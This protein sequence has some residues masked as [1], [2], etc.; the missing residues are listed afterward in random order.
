MRSSASSPGWL[1][2]LIP[3]AGDRA[4]DPIDPAQ[5]LL[6]E[7]EIRTLFLR[8]LHRRRQQ[9]QPEVT[10]T[11]T[12][13]IRSVR[14]GPGLDYEESRA[15]QAGDE[16][17]FMNWRLSARTG[18][19]Q[20]KVF[21]E[22]R[23]PAVVLLIDRRDTMR[24]GTCKRLKLTQALR[25]A[26]VIGATA[27]Q[28]QASVSTLLLDE[29]LRWCGAETSEPG[30]LNLLVAA[31]AAAPPLPIG[32]QAQGFGQALDQLQEKLEPGSSLWL[33]S[34]FIDLTDEH[35]SRLLQLSAQAQVVAATIV[36]PA[37]RQLPTAGRLQFAT[38]QGPLSLDTSAP[39][40]QAAYARM[41]A[42]HYR[43]QQ[44]LLRD[45]G[46]A[47]RSLS[48]LDDDLDAWPDVQPDA[49]LATR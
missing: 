20:R 29:P 21:R 32:R 8:A 46:I 15:Y 41:A 23:R 5:P 1:Q 9:R 11:Q 27:Y 12:G 42:N 16:P 40:V 30:I 37:E 34:D 36:D 2:R 10:G 4:K 22:E 26:T 17:R 33:L 43:R 18:S 39:D 3:A 13:E 35:R 19:L 28:A 7:D 31:A 38:P 44:A 25:L 49:W 6:D 48:S 24:F 14:R 45:S 47:C